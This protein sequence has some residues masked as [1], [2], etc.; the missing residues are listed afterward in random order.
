MAETTI[1]KKICMFYTCKILRHMKQDCSDKK[2]S[3]TG[4]N[5]MLWKWC[6]LHS[7][8]THW[9]DECKGLEENGNASTNTAVVAVSGED[10][11]AASET[12]SGGIWYLVEH[13]TR[14]I[15]SAEDTSCRGKWAV[16]YIALT[17]NSLIWHSNVS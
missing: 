3:I 2:S 14:V 9:G 11:V 4:R 13:Q 17:V 5:G 15:Q 16:D 1:D 12:T 10:T 7:F 6:R 8:T